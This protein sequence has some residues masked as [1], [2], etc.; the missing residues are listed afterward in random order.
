MSTLENIE[1]DPDIQ[2]SRPSYEA[3][4][5]SYATYRNRLLRYATAGRTE[6]GA[7]YLDKYSGISGRPVIATHST[8]W[9]SLSRNTSTAL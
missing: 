8:V 6:V 4:L 2:Q 9:A 7:E 1:T 5:E 3:D